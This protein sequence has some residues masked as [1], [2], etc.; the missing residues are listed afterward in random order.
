MKKTLRLSLNF[1][2][3]KIYKD[4]EG[5]TNC[6][7]SGHH[8]QSLLKKKFNCV[9]ADFRIR[10][11]TNEKVSVLQNYSSLITDLFSSDQDRKLLSTL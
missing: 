10:I 8:E 6:D 7:T 11:T 5:V 9:S 3:E 1:R 2:W 4:N